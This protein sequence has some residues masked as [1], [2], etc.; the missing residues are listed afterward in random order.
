VALPELGLERF[1][2]QVADAVRDGGYDVVFPTRDA[3]VFAV[4]ACRAEL[5][6]VVPYPGH[7]VV[8]RAFDKLEL[9]AQAEA[10]GF[11]PVA[12]ALADDAAIARFA[13]PAVVKAR[14]HWDPAEAGEV[15]H[16]QVTV[17]ATREE[18][19]GAARELA[20]H[21]A[22]PLLQEL[23]SGPVALVA[24]VVDAAGDVLAAGQMEADRLLRGANVRAVSVP[25]DEGLLERLRRLALRMGWVGLAQFDLLR[26]TDGTL[27]PI[28]LNGRWFMSMA[29]IEAAG[30]DLATAWADLALER[31]AGP[32][33]TAA[34]GVRFQWLEGCVVASLKDR[35]P[36][37]LLRALRGQRG[38]VHPYWRRQ[39]ASSVLG[40]DARRLAAEV[41]ALVRPRERTA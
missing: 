19:R 9:A 33:A 13:Y 26:A 39:E 25:V 29:A 40:Y 15:A 2:E 36:R 23:R 10:V 37:E 24:F 4:S 16:H 21:G 32:R 22:E 5:G 20:A 31:G 7:D 34:A 12:T 27:T 6:A 1:V 30:A 14:L 11:H 17:C 35:E 3:E 8:R 18:A 28:D 38:A 41:A